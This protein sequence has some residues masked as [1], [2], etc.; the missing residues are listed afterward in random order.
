MPR[1]SQ[2]RICPVCHQPG[3]G[4][5]PKTVRKGSSKTY[6]YFYHPKWHRKGNTWCYVRKALLR[7]GEEGLVNV[8]RIP[9]ILGRDGRVYVELGRGLEK[10]SSLMRC[11]YGTNPIFWFYFLEK[12]SIQA[13]DGE[14][15]H[16]VEQVCGLAGPRDKLKYTQDPTKC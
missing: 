9:S 15:R 8:K 2:G 14:W 11:S 13:D 12:P 1:P 7:D 4:P 6:W 5:Y 10:G 3:S 16:Q